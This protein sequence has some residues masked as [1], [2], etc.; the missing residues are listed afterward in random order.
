[1]VKSFVQKCNFSIKAYRRR[2]ADE[3]WTMTISIYE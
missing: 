2:F 3:E 1:M